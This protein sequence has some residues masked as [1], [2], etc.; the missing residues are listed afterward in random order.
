MR[1]TFLAIAGAVAI[2][3]ALYVSILYI[4]IGP[5]GP[6]AIISAISATYP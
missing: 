1:D 6:E 3:L 5:V 2:V 4:A